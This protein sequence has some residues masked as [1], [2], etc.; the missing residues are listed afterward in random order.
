VVGVSVGSAVG[1]PG[2]Q[3]DAV[4][5]RADEAMYGAKTRQRRRVGRG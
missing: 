4:I 2:E 1:R 5:A 3:P